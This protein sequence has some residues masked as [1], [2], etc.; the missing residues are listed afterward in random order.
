MC[1]LLFLTKLMCLL[2]FFQRKKTSFIVYLSICTSC[3]AIVDTKHTH[4]TSTLSVRQ[5]HAL[6]S[7]R[8]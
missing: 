3:D 8:E 7:V 2:L 6:F 5:F 4:Y 1:L